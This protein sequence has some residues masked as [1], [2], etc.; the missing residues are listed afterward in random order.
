MIEDCGLRPLVIVCLRR[1]C[2][3]GG[4]KPRPYFC[5]LTGKTL[6]L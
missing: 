1:A 3:A 2:M 5:I 4:G 6:D